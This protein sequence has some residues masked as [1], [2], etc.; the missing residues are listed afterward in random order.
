MDEELIGL[1]VHIFS[2]NIKRTLDN[3]FNKYHLTSV[4]SAVLEY[5]YKR[6]TK[7]EKVY[8]KDIEK[9]FDMRRAT[10]AGILQLLEKQGLIIRELE[11][12]DS[13]LK[14]IILTEKALEVQ[15]EIKRAIE[16]NERK[17]RKNIPK[18][19]IKQFLKILNKMYNNLNN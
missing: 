3:V 16:E 15:K 2:R 19:E 4:Q 7:G 13:R 17:I 9:T 6:N 5:I 8:S 18:E 1:N 11:N 12:K 10:S 14:N